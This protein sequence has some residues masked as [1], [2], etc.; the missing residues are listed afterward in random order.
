M[1]FAMS[2]WIFLTK[3]GVGRIVNGRSKAEICMIGC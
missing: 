1:L 3:D 2:V